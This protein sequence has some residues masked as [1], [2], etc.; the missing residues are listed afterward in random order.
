VLAHPLDTVP[1]GVVVVGAC[2]ALDSLDEVLRSAGTGSAAFVS[3]PQGKNS[4]SD[5]PSR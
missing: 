1:G 2:E 4:E 5:C 3:R